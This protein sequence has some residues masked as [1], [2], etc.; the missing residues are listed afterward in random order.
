MS[1]ASR[2]SS[3]ISLS[4]WLQPDGTGAETETLGIK[5]LALSKSKLKSSL[6]ESIPILGPQDAPNLRSTSE[7]RTKGHEKYKQIGHH[8]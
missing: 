3:V 4:H 1:V 5:S 8:E 2:V 7:F 6:D